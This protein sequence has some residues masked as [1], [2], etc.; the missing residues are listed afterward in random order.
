MIAR[1]EY[2]DLSPG[3]YSGFPLPVLAFGWLGLRHGVQ[4]AGEPP[5]TDAEVELLRAVSH[6]AAGLMLGFH[7][8]EFC[9]AARGNGEH[10]Y[11]LPG[12]EIL[13]APVMVLHYVDV[14]GYRPPARLRENL[15]AVARPRWDWRAERLVAVLADQDEDFDLRCQ[16]AVDLAQFRDRRAYDALLLA[17]RDEELVDSAGDEVGLSLAAFV[18]HGLV[19]ALPAGNWHSMVRIGIDQALGSP[20]AGQAGTDASGD[21]RSTGRRSE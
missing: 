15:H 17:A 1:V 6:R 12:G 9:G 10:R 16:A 18:H 8:C 13:T 4:G 19:E 5:M 20:P 21:Q 3:D 14:H 11:Y 7:V 2:L